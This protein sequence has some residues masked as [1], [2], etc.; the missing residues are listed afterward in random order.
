[1]TPA[2]VEETAFRWSR[3]LPVFAVLIVIS[4]LAMFNHQKSSSSVVS[5]TLYALRTSPRARELLGDDIYFR[6]RV[7][8]IAGDLKPVQGVIDLSFSVRGSR[9]WGVMTFRS[10]RP[11][12]KGMFETEE[13]SLVMEGTGEKIDLM[14]GGDP[15]KAIPGAHPDDE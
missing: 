13:W 6:R 7:P 12:A 14:E 10:I 5:A 3:T 1:M 2:D 11:S 8:Y 9:G 15:F 4:S